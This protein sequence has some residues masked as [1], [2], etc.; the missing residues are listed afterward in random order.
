MGFF[1]SNPQSQNQWNLLCFLI[2]PFEILGQCWSHSACCGFKWD[3][4]RTIANSEHWHWGIVIFVSPS[5]HPCHG[6]GNVSVSL[7]QKRIQSSIQE[8]DCLV[9]YYPG[10]F[11]VALPSLLFFFLYLETIQITSISAQSRESKIQ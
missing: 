3:W 8:P 1:F 9:L 4:N 2:Q 7:Q 6:H 10:N 5:Q 11:K